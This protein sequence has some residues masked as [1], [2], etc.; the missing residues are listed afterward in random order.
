MPKI[1]RGEMGY[2]GLQYSEKDKGITSIR[3]VEGEKT[4]KLVENLSAYGLLIFN[5]GE[6]IITLGGA[7]LVVAAVYVLSSLHGKKC[8][9]RIAL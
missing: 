1:E 8:R 7:V 4:M 5:P 9:A 2:S 3:L 6:M